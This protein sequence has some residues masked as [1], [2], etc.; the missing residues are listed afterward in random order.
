MAASPQWWWTASQRRALMVLIGAAAVGFAVKA[1]F[2]PI[3]VPNPFNSAGSRAG[4]LADKINPNTATAAMLA[5]LPDLGMARARVIVDYRQDYVAAHPGKA[6]FGRAD[7][8]TN[9]KGI[10][11]AMVEKLSPY[12][13]FQQP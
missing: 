3:F 7:D 2:N 5:T 6:A 4:E 1:V 13:E 9:V 12:L 8:L 10:G 11:A